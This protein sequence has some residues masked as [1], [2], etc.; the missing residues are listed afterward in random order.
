MH[1]TLHALHWTP[2]GESTQSN[3]RCSGKIFTLY[4][5]HL[6]PNMTRALQFSKIGS[7]LNPAS[8]PTTFESLGGPTGT[9]IAHV[10]VAMLFSQYRFQLPMRRSR[11]QRCKLFCAKRGLGQTQL[12]IRIV[13]AQRC[14]MT[15]ATLFS[16]CACHSCTCNGT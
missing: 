14:E 16:I 8:F 2:Q 15:N 13:L 10:I 6:I 1:S 12:N 9:L 4:V 11:R 5:A 7:T 3:T